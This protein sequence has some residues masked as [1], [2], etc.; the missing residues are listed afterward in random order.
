MARDQAAGGRVLVEVGEYSG[1]SAVVIAAT[2]LRAAYSERRKRQ[3]VD[4]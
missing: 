3:I 2:Q 4:E 1:E